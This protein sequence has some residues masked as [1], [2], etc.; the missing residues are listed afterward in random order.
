MLK[1]TEKQRKEIKRKIKDGN[2]E[3]KEKLWNFLV[4]NILAE[5][6]NRQKYV[7]KFTDSSL[8]VSDEC[9]VWFEAEPKSPRKGRRGNTEGNTKLDLAF[10]ALSNRE[11]KDCG[12]KYNKSTDI[13][14]VC[15]VEAKY[16]SEASPGIAHDETKNQITRVIENLLCF[17]TKRDYPDELY[18][19]MLT[20]RKYANI[21][22]VEK[23]YQNIMR[24]YRSEKNIIEDIKESKIPRRN[25][26]RWGYP[27]IEKRIELL[28]INWIS[29]EEILESYYPDIEGLDLI[30]LK[31]E[32]EY[33]RF[34]RSEIEKFINL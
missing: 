31:E 16:T 9:E 21:D 20:P 30:E 17:Q 15:F 22:G 2:L 28:D 29:Y 7:R 5:A 11:N 1:T 27:D 6:E 18:F 24:R 34:L 12:I 23:N 13:S 14:W 25:E 33:H 3:R 10:G 8:R 26:S 32:D 4:G 19:T